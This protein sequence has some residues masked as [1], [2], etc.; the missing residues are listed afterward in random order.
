MAIIFILKKYDFLFFYDPE[1][2]VMKVYHGRNL[3]SIVQGVLEI[4]SSIKLL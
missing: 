1:I 4:Q 3:G 2:K